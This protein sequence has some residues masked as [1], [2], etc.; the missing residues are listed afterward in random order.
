MRWLQ[1]RQNGKSGW[2]LYLMIHFPF[3]WWVKIGITGRTAQKRANDLHGVVF[4][5]A[6]P[7]FVVILPEAHYWEQSLHGFCRP[8]RARFYRGDGAGEWFWFPAAV[9][10]LVFMLAVWGFYFWLIGLVTD[11]DGLDWYLT[12]LVAIGEWVMNL[13]NA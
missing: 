9:P 1:R 6:I 11:W 4:G 3:I 10:V 5:F 7:V 2:I 8:F 13:M 12:T